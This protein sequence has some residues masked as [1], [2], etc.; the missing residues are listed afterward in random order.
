MYAHGQWNII[1]DVCGVEYKSSV[2][3]KR[4]D[5]LLV[6]D[7]DFEY[8][9]PQKHIRAISDPKPVPADL[10]RYEPTDVFIGVC[11][12]YTSQ[13][14]PSIGIPGCIIPSKNTGLPPH[15]YGT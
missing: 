6:C 4:W 2:I 3:R 9:H 1:C 7:K 8:D 11:T 12:V 5:G 13:A 14:I 10:I 15:I